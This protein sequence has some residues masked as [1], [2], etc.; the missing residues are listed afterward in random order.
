MA[1][2]AAEPPPKLQKSTP[3]TIEEFLTLMASP[4]YK[5]ALQAAIDNSLKNHFN[6]VIEKLEKE[7]EM[8]N[9]KLKKVEGELAEYDKKISE[10]NNYIKQGQLSQPGS[11][12]TA[13]EM[14]RKRSIVII[15]IPEVGNSSREK[16]SWD[17]QCL[18]KVLHFLDIAS[19]PVS[20]YRLGRPDGNRPRLMKVVFPRSL[21][22]KICYK[23]QRARL[24]LPPDYK[25]TDYVL[26]KSMLMNANWSNILGVNGDPNQMYDDFLA[27]IKMTYEACVPWQEICS[28]SGFLP[29]YL[30]AF[31][32][33]VNHNFLIA[34]K[35][36]SESD[37]K[38]YIILARRFRKKLSKFR[39]KAE[40]N[41]LIAKGASKFS[42]FA[43]ILL[44]QRR[45]E[46][47]DF[48]NKEGILLTD[49]TDKHDWKKVRW[50]WISC[51]YAYVF[52]TA[53]PCYWFFPDQKL[54]V[55]RIFE[56][57]PCLP[58]YIYEAPV[59]VLAENF[60]YHLVVMDTFITICTL[61]VIAMVSY[62]SC[63]IVQQL[64]VKKLSQKTYEMQKNFLSALLLQVSIPLMTII[65]P[66]I[67]W[68]YL[69]VESVYK[70][71]I[72]NIGILFL[73]SH[74]CLATIVMMIAHRPYRE[75]ILT[76]VRKKPIV[77]V[78]NSR[79][80][81]SAARNQLSDIHS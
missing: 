15:N 47:P 39:R 24:F 70:Q 29:D 4:Q 67:P 17:N 16:W 34:D 71:W 76:M 10:L 32:N 3:L 51:H 49:K 11:P 79:K 23:N 7:V 56:T 27:Y 31:R 63:T 2:D 78:D 59:F 5:D 38:N 74:G 53:I 66:I 33:L 6:P 64:K 19:P 54:A 13:E 14:E 48:L 43:K 1:S 21:D 68:L 52:L 26:L 30:I 9:D 12:T 25:N 40:L 35:S 75:A 28:D 73:T 61:E 46:L 42:H 18:S 72:V 65:L 20:F 57:L 58:R 69:I 81:I 60:L 62:M 37:F 80:I 36:R 45:S 50:I 8:L 41:K 55:R 44:K 77:K 22:Q